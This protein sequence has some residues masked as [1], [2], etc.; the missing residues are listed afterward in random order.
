MSEEMIPIGI[1]DPLSFNCSSDVSCFNECCRDLNQFLTPYDVLRL[2]NNLTVSSDVFLRK[3]T[4]RHTG[5]ESGLPVI[6]FKADPD[7]GLACP[8]VTDAGCSVYKDR[9]AS[10]RLYPLARAITRS[11]ETGVIT[12]H[13]ALIEEPHCKGFGRSSGQSVRQWLKGQDVALHNE[14]NDRMMEII[15][16]KNQIMPGR[17]DGADSDLFYLALY[18][19]DTFRAKLF[20][21]DAKEMIMGIELPESFFDKI[22]TD[23]VELLNFGMTWIKY[24]FFGVDAR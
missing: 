23:D 20:A 5:P 8:F 15:S 18:D 12:E 2:K 19:L 24:R 9:P 16:L 1:D 10:C 21:S 22:K 17:L 11:R 4:S 13:F 6:T 3:Y 7:S 14:M